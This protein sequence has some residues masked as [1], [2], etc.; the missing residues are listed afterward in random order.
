MKK[1]FLTDHKFSVRA[2]RV[3]EL[4]ST[5]IQFLLFFFVS[6]PFKVI[7]EVYEEQAKQEPAMQKLLNAIVAVLYARS[8]ENL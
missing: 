1:T 8:P 2:L 4:K 3:F 5:C 7:A 6:F